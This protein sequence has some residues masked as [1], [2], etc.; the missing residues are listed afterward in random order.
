MDGR[1]EK[2]PGWAGRIDHRPRVRTA[3][4]HAS[5]GQPARAARAR[6]DD[7]AAAGDVRVLARIADGDARAL[8]DLYERYSGPLFA[9]LYRLCGDRGTAE[10]ILQDTVM[11]VWLSAASY[12]QRSSVSTW[13]FGVARRQAHN[14]LRGMPPPIAAEPREGPDPLPGPEE[15]AVGGDQVQ[16]ALARLPLPHREV[17]VLLLVHDLTQREIAE[18]LGIPV[19]TVKSRLHHARAILRG[20]A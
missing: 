6:R 18:V 13:L 1:A 19:G 20:P 10:E 5:D 14:R 2:M 7:R 8:A 11:A 15:L 17:V 3:L 4:V 9:F 16:S 12:R